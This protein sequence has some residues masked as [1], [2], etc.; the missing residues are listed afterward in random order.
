MV[1]EGSKREAEEGSRRGV[2]EGLRVAGR[3]READ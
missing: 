1:E 2:K 3:D